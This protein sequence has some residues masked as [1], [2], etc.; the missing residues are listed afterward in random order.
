[1]TVV[2]AR[3]LRAAE[4]LDMAA[5]RM[6]AMR[7]PATPWGISLDDEG[8]EDVVVGAEG[9]G[10]LAVED[11]EADADEEEEGELEEDDGSGGEEGES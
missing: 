9:G 2:E 4:R 1:M 10:W 7:R 3:E 8:G 6:A 11:E 5:A